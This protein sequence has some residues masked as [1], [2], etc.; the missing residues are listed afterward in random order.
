[1]HVRIEMEN[2]FITISQAGW[3]PWELRLL[4][5]VSTLIKEAYIP[6][7]DGNLGVS[8]LTTTTTTTCDTFIFGRSLINR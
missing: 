1:M 2:S 6:T 7:E 5:L 3:S 8:R 4:T